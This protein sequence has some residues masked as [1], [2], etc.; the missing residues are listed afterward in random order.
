MDKET[1]NRIKA[2]V[3]VGVSIVV[4]FSVLRN[5]WALASGTVILSIVI[6]YTA[7][8]QVDVVLYDER[9]VIIREKAANATLNLVTVA[10][11]AIGLGLIETSFWG[12]SVNKEYGYLFTNIAFIIMGVNALFNWYYNNKLGG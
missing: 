1:Y 5:S 9:T 7:K 10:F 6:L 4:A 11:A 8:K 3:A 12:Y 2:A